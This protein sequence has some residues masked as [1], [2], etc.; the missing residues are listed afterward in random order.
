[1]HLQADYERYD[2]KLRAELNNADFYDLVGP[3]KTGRKGYVFGVGT[4]RPLIYDEPNRSTSTLDG[5]YSGN[6]D[7]LPEYQN[8][9]VDVTTLASAQREA[10]VHERP[11]VAGQRRR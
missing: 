11:V 3:T 2:W 6:L 7:R 4:R 5:S 1:M 9:P 8:V 10:D